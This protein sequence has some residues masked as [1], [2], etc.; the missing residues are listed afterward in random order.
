MSLSEQD[1]R[2]NRDQALILML[3]DLA[4]RAV[5]P[6]EESAGSVDEP[7][8]VHYLF[9]ALAL[10][11]ALGAWRLYLSACVASGERRR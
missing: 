6:A 5:W 1:R 7:I 9:T 3:E 10:L 4:G 11:A 2:A 8:R